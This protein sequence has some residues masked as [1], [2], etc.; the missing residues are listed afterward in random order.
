MPATESIVDRRF[1]FQLLAL[2]VCAVVAIVA[3][4]VVFSQGMS[5]ARPHPRA[6]PEY[7]ELMGDHAQLLAFAGIGLF[8]AGMGLGILSRFH[9]QEQAR[10]LRQKE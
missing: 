6:D 7:A 3:G 8:C 2:N 5:F 9:A 4:A 1:R 10:R